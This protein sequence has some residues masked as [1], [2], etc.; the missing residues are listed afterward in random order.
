MDYEKNLPTLLK[1]VLK[2]ELASLRACSYQSLLSLK[3]GTWCF[4]ILFF[5]LNMKVSTTLSACSVGT[6]NKAFKC[7]RISFHTCQRILPLAV[8]E[9]LL[10]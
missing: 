1:L 9:V 6:L 2:L 5:S 3:R 4:L 8:S 10:P 7:P